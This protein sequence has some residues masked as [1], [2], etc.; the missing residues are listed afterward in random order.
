MAFQPE[1]AHVA[2]FA[3]FDRPGTTYEATMLEVAAY[4]RRVGLPYRYWLADSWWYSKGPETAGVP[5]PG[6][7]RWEPMRTIFPSGEDGFGALA[8][9]T[10]WGL[11]AHN[12][13]WSASTP[14]ARQNGGEWPFEVDRATGFAVPLG[15]AF[16]DHLFGR[17]RER[18]WR[19][20]TYEQDWMNFQHERMQVLTRDATAARAWLRDMGDAALSAGVC[21]QYC[22]SYS[23]HVLQSVESAAVT[24]VVTPPPPPLSPPSRLS[25]VLSSLSSLSPI[26]SHLRTSPRR[27]AARRVGHTHARHTRTHARTCTHATH[28][29]THARARTPHT[30]MQLTRTHARTAGARQRRLPRRQRPVAAARA[31]GAAA[32]LGRPRRLQGHLLVRD[33][34]AGLQVG[35]RHARAVPA[36]AG[37]GRD[38]LARAGDGERCRQ[39]LASLGGVTPLLLLTALLTV[40]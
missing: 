14:Y 16:W 19:L 15:R 30:R 6:V 9:A 18:G 35:R 11:M 25:P 24:Q 4:A 22:M 38:A 10:G 32:A 23:R 3:A 21:V 5:R 36:A 8:N 31:D 33:D 40:V 37:G 12:R 34:A 2:M 13:Y 39:H 7:A 1:A 26:L 29:R 17:A 27:R 20:A 28:A